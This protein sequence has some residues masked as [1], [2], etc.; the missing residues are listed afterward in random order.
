MIKSEE[1]TNPASCMSRA[2]DDE[3]TFVL[4]GRDAAAPAT[5]RFWVKER[6]R[7]GKN[8][9][10]DEQLHA[11]LRAAALIEQR[12]TAS[13]EQPGNSLLAL[14]PRED[15]I[16]FRAELGRVIIAHPTRPFLAWSGSRWVP[17]FGS[18]QICNFDS[19]ADARA[20]LSAAE[21]DDAL[22]AHG[23]LA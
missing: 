17:I 23:G 1:L 18:V 20:Y 11:A 16:S 21:E 8:T 13:A 3:F 12:Q 2:K 15:H 22:V 5:I 9:W 10:A 6:L 4:L 19:E 7:L 14:R